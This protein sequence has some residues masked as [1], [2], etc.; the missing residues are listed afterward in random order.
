M[1]NKKIIFCGALLIL[2]TFSWSLLAMSNEPVQKEWTWETSTPEKQGIDSERVIE[3]FN[4]IEQ[5][6]MNLSSLLIARNGRIITE[7]YFAPYDKNTR[8][9]LYSASKS[10]LSALVGIALEEGDLK[11]IDQRVAEF[12]PQYYT[13]NMDPRKKEITIKDLLKM[14][15]GYE[16]S[17]NY[18]LNEIF[19]SRNEL[20]K[21]IINRKLV[22]KPGKEFRY[23]N[24]S[25]QLIAEILREA[26]GKSIFAYAQQHL[27]QPLGIE[28][29]RWDKLPSGHYI[30]SSGV[31]LTPRQMAKFGHLYLNEG[32]WQGKQ[33]VP[34]SWVK[35][36]TRSYIA[37]RNPWWDYGY[38]WW[39]ARNVYIASGYGGQRIMVLP[40]ADM[41]IVI[42]AE[43]NRPIWQ[44]LKD[45]I[46]YFI[47]A[48]ESPLEP[49]PEANKKL[50][51]IV[52]KLKNSEPQEVATLPQEAIEISGQTYKLQ[53][54]RLRME[55]IKFNF[56]NK[57]DV[58]YITVNG[59]KIKVGLDGVYRESKVDSY[60]SYSKVKKVA[61]KGS[62][63]EKWNNKKSFLL[64]VNYI[65]E[66]EVELE[67]NFKDNGKLGVYLTDLAHSHAPSF[68]KGEMVNE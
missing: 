20:A 7:A 11:S 47:G 12:F 63:K 18:K 8:H 41:V 61:A 46:P 22:S 6:G 49:N 68:F 35:E 4:K 67:I 58:A 24:L 38:Q 56:N 1:K 27:F 40:E 33:V 59:Q 64:N 43:E 26:T 29:V 16:A 45:F 60:Y 51:K 23:D 55:K 9:N 54:N 52:S 57:E 34:T 10:V 2:F 17:D 48:E 37:T 25:S 44:I 15:A 32:T 19:F 65:G 50:T 62:W 31:H 3:L 5:K 42:T 36:S 21:R 13:E 30:G 28:D 14:S 53:D 66:T 39:T